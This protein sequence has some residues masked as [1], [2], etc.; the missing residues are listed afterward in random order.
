VEFAVWYEVTVETG[1]PAPGGS[2]DGSDLVWRGLIRQRRE[3][4]YIDCSLA[5]GRYRYRIQAFNILNRGGEVSE[6]T[7]FEVRPALGEGPVQRLS[8]SNAEFTAACVVMFEQQV[9]G[10][11]SAGT[12]ESGVYRE[13]LRELR[14][15]DSFIEVSLPPGKYRFRVDPYDILGRPGEVSG[16]EY[17]EISARPPEP[18]RPEPESEKS[19]PVQEESVPV[20]EESAPE[21]EESVP[22][23]PERKF[24]RDSFAE[25]L[26]A[27]ALP[28]LF[29]FFNKTYDVAF[30]PAGAAVKFG[31]LFSPE[32]RHALGFDLVPSWNYLYA[33]KPDY[34]IL[35]HLLTLHLNFV[36]HYSFSGLP[37]TLQVEAGGG[38]SLLYDF[39]FEQP[40]QRL[41]KAINTWIPSA[42]AGLSL[43]W[44]FRRPFYL[45][46]GAEYLHI[47]SVDNLFLNFIHPFAGIGMTF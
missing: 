46:L 25:I 7:F 8:W 42:S 16:W 33:N 2:A 30:Q 28:L 35:A 47:F 11:G 40:G 43:H 15:G 32:P 18:E 10:E 1:E 45:T 39:H 20:Q 5:P 6:W 44:V 3:L 37:L 4:P 26:Y 38:F 13:I 23:R 17:F 31:M 41:D 9:E 22:A 34:A 21:Q 27:P 29:S 14:R 19:A 36:Y 12:G 24:F